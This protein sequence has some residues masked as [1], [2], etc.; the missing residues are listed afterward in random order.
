IDAV[1]PGGIAPAH[2]VEEP[3]PPI[4][5]A[6][7]MVG[8]LTMIYV[9]SFID[10][11]ILSLIADP[12]KRDLQISDTLMSL[13]MGISFVFFYTLFG[14]PLGR[15]ADAKSRRTIITVGCA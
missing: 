4:S 1:A 14:I 7:Y 6:L 3:F 13:L 5:S 2:T 9:F 8:I 15:L 10:R 11:Q 12:I